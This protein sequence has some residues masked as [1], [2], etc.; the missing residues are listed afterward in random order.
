MIKR[1]EG[2]NSFVTS[3]ERLCELHFDPDNIHRAPGGRKRKLKEGANPV[4][5]AWN[6]FGGLKNIRKPPTFT[7]PPRKQA[8]LSSDG[9][10][11]EEENEQV[12]SMTMTSQ[13]SDT[14]DMTK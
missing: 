3:N 1:Q 13:A 11:E 5:H 2:K 12:L 10:K 9:Y 7:P 8:N 4:R 6:D 14:S